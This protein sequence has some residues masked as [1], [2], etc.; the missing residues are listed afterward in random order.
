M[1]PQQLDHVA[2]HAHAQLDAGR[3]ACYVTAEQVAGL[4][5]AYARALERLAHIATVADAALL[6]WCD[7]SREELRADLLN[8]KSLA[9]LDKV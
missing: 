2:R 9:T 5:D 4:A 8:V 1:T 3:C 6:H 7:H